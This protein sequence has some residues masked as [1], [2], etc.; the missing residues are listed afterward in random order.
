MLDKIKYSV[1]K[2]NNDMLILATGNSA[3]QQVE[4]QGTL[5]IRL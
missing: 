3:I 5:R 2:R 4:R 1:K